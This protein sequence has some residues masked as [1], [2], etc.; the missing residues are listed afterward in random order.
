MAI[1]FLRLPCLVPLPAPPGSCQSLSRNVRV[2]RL[3]FIEVTRTPFGTSGS[4]FA[5]LISLPT[6]CQVCSSIQTPEN[7]ATLLHYDLA[8]QILRAK[9]RQNAP[10]DWRSKCAIRENS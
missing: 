10:S 4:L 7:Y 9:M 5:K 8:P 2:T 1:C 3:T 6:C